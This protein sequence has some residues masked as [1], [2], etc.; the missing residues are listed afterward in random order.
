MLGGIGSTAQS[1]EQNFGWTSEADH[2]GFLVVF[3]SAVATD[4]SQ[5]YDRKKNFTFW[6]MQGSRTHILTSGMNPVDDDGYLMAVLRDFPADHP[7]AATFPSGFSSGSGMVQLFAAR[8]SAQVRAI[9]AVATP[10][11][12][13]PIKLAHPVAVLYIHGDHEHPL[14]RL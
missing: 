10:L 9:A 14:L 11:M 6:E 8:H 13:P 7:I 4:P 3:P 2:N 5:P 1:T 12:E